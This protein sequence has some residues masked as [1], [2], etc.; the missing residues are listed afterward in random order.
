[1]GAWKYWVFVLGFEDYFVDLAFYLLPGQELL[2]DL[3]FLVFAELLA[4]VVQAFLSLALR[5]HLLNC[6]LE[7]F[8]K[9]GL[10]DLSG[11]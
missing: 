11:H 7:E 8:L 1:M 3:L 4:A 9:C 6:G 5:T 10:L 2:H